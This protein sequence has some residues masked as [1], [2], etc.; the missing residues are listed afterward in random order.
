[1]LART[2]A[3]VLAG[4]GIAAA[5]EGPPVGDQELG[6]RLGLALNL[7]GIAP[8]GVRLDGV[9]LYRLSDR[10]W[11]DGRADFTLG[12]GGSSCTF[13]ATGPSRCDHTVT[14]GF[15]ALA[16]AGA[17]WFP[18]ASGSV[19]PWVGGGL[20]AGLA[21]LTGDDL[22][23]FQLALWASAGAR[24]PVAEGVAL[25]GEGMLSTAATAFGKGI[26][27][28]GSVGLAVLLGVDFRM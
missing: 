19:T 27:W 8:G 26:G 10:V 14:D 24:L 12:G 4:A 28:Q 20:G 11:F 17:R 23:G 21:D 16:L 9:W 13:P 1:V 5:Q 22:R 7:A 18:P 2:V 3:L 15:A 6:A 25:A